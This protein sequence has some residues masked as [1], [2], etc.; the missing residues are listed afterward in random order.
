MVRAAVAA[1]VI[2][3]VAE[4]RAALVRF[5]AARVDDHAAAEDIVHDV[6][7]RAWE[8]RE[9]LRDAAKLGPWLYQMTRNAIV[10][11]HRAQKPSAELPED[12]PAADGDPIPAQELAQCLTPLMARLPEHYRAAIELSEIEGLTQQ[13]TAKRLGVT[14]SGAKSRV[15]RGRAKLQE[16][17]LACCRLELD[18]R[19]S[20]RD[21]EPRPNCACNRCT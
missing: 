13:E 20:I 16:M 3:A 5:V 12:L 7:L 9:Q 10:D 14:L 15:Q 1:D 11:H 17:I 6:L 4:H 21:Y 18:H 19:G 8:R 2:D